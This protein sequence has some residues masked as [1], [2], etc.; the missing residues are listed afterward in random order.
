MDFLAEAIEKLSAAPRQAAELVHGLSEE[1]LSWKP[2][3]ETFSM[4]ENILHL[5]DID[6]EGYEHSMRRILNEEAPTLQDV[7]GGKLARER[8]YNVQP[9]EPALLEFG[10]SRATSMARLSGCSLADLERT[11]EMEGSGKVTLRRLLE[12]WIRHD[13]DHLAD[14]VNLRRV[15]NGEEAQSTFP[16]HQ[17]A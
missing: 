12:M 15:L 14:M 6:V 4:R 5:R 9:V 3:P 8:N 13:A 1:Q 17:A 16:E 11:A 7:N 10:R 2:A